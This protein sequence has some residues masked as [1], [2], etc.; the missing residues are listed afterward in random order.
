MRFLMCVYPA[1]CRGGKGKREG[2]DFMPPV[3]TK[4]FSDDMAKVSDNVKLKTK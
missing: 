3:D 1:V 4:C 2:V